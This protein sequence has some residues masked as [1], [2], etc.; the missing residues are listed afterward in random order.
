MAVLSKVGP[1]SSCHSGPHI[2]A[3]ICR[4]IR[5]RTS[6]MT[7]RLRTVRDWTT[8]LT[9]GMVVHKRVLK[10]EYTRLQS[11][12]GVSSIT[13]CVVGST[14]DWSADSRSSSRSQRIWVGGL[15]VMP[16]AASAVLRRAASR[17]EISPESGSAYTIIQSEKHRGT[18]TSPRRCRWNPASSTGW[19]SDPTFT[20]IWGLAVAST[21]MGEAAT[22]MF[23][24]LATWNNGS[25]S[26]PL[27]NCDATAIP[28]WCRQLAWR[29]GSWRFPV[30]D[31]RLPMKQQSSGTSITSS[32][33]L[34]ACSSGCGPVIL[35][36]YLVAKYSANVVS[37]CCCEGRSFLKKV[38]CG[39]KSTLTCLTWYTRLLYRVTTSAPWHSP[40][41]TPVA[42]GGLSAGTCASTADNTVSFTLSAWI[43]P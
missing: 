4:M 26:S 37:V 40:A 22:C 27:L 17:F 30:G 16:K 10:I 33:L 5:V 36:L 13:N 29:C 32:L 1:R 15:K 7:C 31:P 21:S 14:A 42:S 8:W 24:F 12:V 38:L 41:Q 6:A 19:D 25:P 23:Q 11:L 43:C 3:L 9:Q 35:A 39:F 18:C 34:V 20:C 2:F 28:V